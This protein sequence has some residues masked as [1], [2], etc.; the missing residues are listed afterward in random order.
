MRARPVR[1]N[2][3]IAWLFM[4]GSACFA[5]GT[6][7]A[8]ASAVGATADAITFF[9]GS[10]FFTSASFSQLVQSQ[11]PWMTGVDAA[12]QD[13]PAPVVVRAWL[14]GDRNWLAAATQFPGTLFF[15][16]STLAA[17]AHN[18][19]AREADRYVWRP[20]FF[21]SILFL[22][23]ST[24]AILALGEGFLAWRPRLLLWWIAWLNML[25]SVAFMASALASFVLPS[26]GGLIDEPLANAGTFIG[27][28]CFLVGAALMLPA[29]RAAVRAAGSTRRTVGEAT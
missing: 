7:P 22:V 19:T 3:T 25:G 6:V 21:G 15:N 23:A 26:T 10:L 14:P 24:F 16:I 29:W 27:A 11:S 5:L 18:L 2:A 4:I 12:A 8:Y 9:I 13:V 17:V 20:D 1:L 28:V